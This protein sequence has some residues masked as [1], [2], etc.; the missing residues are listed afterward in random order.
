MLAGLP[1]LTDTMA[2]GERAQG[3][4][5]KN[6]ATGLIVLLGLLVIVLTLILA[7]ALVKTNAA[8]VADLKAINEGLQKYIQENTASNIALTR[9]VE[10]KLATKRRTGSHEALPPPKEGA[11]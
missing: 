6:L 9:A 8:R 1:S 2:A 4:L 5:D 10:T 11:G 7:T 3:M